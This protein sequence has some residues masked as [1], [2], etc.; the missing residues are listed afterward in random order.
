L[1][2][3]NEGISQKITTKPRKN[4]KTHVINVSLAA[5]LC[6]SS[7]AA[8]LITP[9]DPVTGIVKNGASTF[10]ISTDFPGGETPV[11]AIDGNNGS[12]YLNFT[13]LNTGLVV[14]PLAFYTANSVTQSIVTG[15]SLTTADDN[16][17]RDPLT[18]SIYGTN[19]AN[20]TTFGD[21]SAIVLDQA[22]LAP[23]ARQ[24]SSVLVSFANTAAFN[25]YAII[26]PTVRDSN[27]NSMQV[28][29]IRLEGTAIPEPS[30]ALLGGLGILTLL[31]RRRSA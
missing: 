19:V 4:M 25:T 28:A 11:Q 18:F 30:A 17:A 15:F 21:Y 3:F 5:L 8:S 20:S 16:D 26:F 7:F 10:T 9:G 6:S 13:K 31:V 14:R 23:T 29:E 24:T 22:T 2:T 27:N 12:K 1:V